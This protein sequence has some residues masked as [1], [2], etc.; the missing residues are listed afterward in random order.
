[1]S[2]EATPDVM[3]GLARLSDAT[4][5]SRSRIAELGIKALAHGD[6]PML[7]TYASEFDKAVERGGR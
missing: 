3:A 2:V 5:P 4:G 6:I 7:Q 1:M